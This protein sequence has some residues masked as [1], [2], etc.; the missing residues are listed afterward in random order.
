MRPAPGNSIA[1]AGSRKLGRLGMLAVILL[2]GGIATA[3]GQTVPG[4]K[5]FKTLAEYKKD[6]VRPAGVRYLPE[7]PYTAAKESLGAKLF[8]DPRL[9]VAD[10]LSC[11]SCHMPGLAWTDGR[12]KS[13]GHD[14]IPHVRH[15]PTL[16][17][18]AWTE[19]TAWD[20]RTV[21]LEGHIRGPLGNPTGMN[22]QPGPLVEKIKG[23]GG[24]P[25]LFD[26]AFPG[27]GVSIDNVVKAIAV[28]E[29]GL[30]SGTAPFDRWIAGDEQ[31][32]PEPAKR[33]F[34]LFNT[35]ANC[36]SC[37]SGW[38]FTDNSFY[39]I[40]MTDADL[41]RIK[42]LNLP[43]MDHAFKTPTLREV[44][45]TDPYMHDGSFSTLVKVVDHYN[46][47]GVAKRESLSENVRPLGLTP[48]EIADLVEFLKTLTSEMPPFA[49]PHL[50]PRDHAAK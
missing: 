19:L 6:Y 3:I 26:A 27:E 21:E 8:F 14:G 50:P 10:D 25:K 48:P 34:M 30:V 5:P 38:N 15:A 23:I 24:Y 1:S 18:L 7:N 45:R 13:V 29:R 22:H 31:A 20:G 49:V 28:F 11:S 44:E 42:I 37:H 12:A 32:I 47:G 40:G 9:S 16:L 46:R 41:G 35:K 2:A 43:S 17:N 4:Q 36:A 39:D 33:G